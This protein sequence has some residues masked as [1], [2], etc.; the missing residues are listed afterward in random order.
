MGEVDIKSIQ[1]GFKEYEQ[2]ERSSQHYT[3]AKHVFDMRFNILSSI[4]LAIL[5]LTW[6]TPI[7]G[8]TP[9]KSQESK[10]AQ[11]M[12]S[13]VRIE[14][15]GQDGSVKQGT[16]VVIGK[17]KVLT[18]RHIVENGTVKIIKSKRIWIEPIITLHPDLDLALIEIADLGIPAVPMKKNKPKVGD[19]VW[20]I[21]NPLGLN[22]SL[23]SGIISAI[24]FEDNYDYAQFTAPISPG[25]SG[26]GLF[27]RNYNLIGI[28]TFTLKGGQNINFGI[29]VWDYEKI[30]KKLIGI[31]KYVKIINN[32][33]I[34]PK[35]EIK[36]KLNELMEENKFQEVESIAKKIVILD[37]SFVEGWIALAF[38]L[39]GQDK[40]E[41]AIAA[42]GK[43]LALDSTDFWIK[44]NYS[45]LLNKMAARES[46]MG[47][48]NN[49]ITIAQKSVKINQA[50]PVSWH[51]LSIIWLKEN[52]YN[53]ALSAIE[54]ASKTKD[55]YFYRSYI[56]TQF[57]IKLMPK[58]NNGEFAEF[59]GHVY[60]TL[61]AIPDV[62]NKNY[63]D[64]MER[65]ARVSKNSHNQEEA[66]NNIRKINQA[67]FLF[68][69]SQFEW[70]D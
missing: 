43:A 21:S 67:Y 48:S 5:L 51:G 45:K 32:E 53:S 66:N 15:V 9:S 39:H 23:S 62:Y 54:S 60:G 22:E 35:N 65:M 31:Q 69:Y 49:A 58:M 6:L 2:F 14:S 3:H 61:M 11:T 68:G 52:N 55:H 41:E 12:R 18:N 64:W 1:I 28:T 19:N 57:K 59:Q 27:D 63:W 29:A 16:G 24:R 17:N 38:G 47:N 8:Q 50:S 13:I 37:P 36:D 4:R 40:F 42:Y 30:S 10:A 33:K 26:G 46:S 56:Y 25:S 20:V 7:S 70:G 34:D 44:N